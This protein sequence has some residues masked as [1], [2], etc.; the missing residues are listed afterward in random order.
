MAGIHIDRDHTLNV[1]MGATVSMI[2]FGLFFFFMGFFD[3]D[4]GLAYR[5]MLAGVESVI[6]AY[7]CDINGKPL[8]DIIFE[9][10]PVKF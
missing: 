6:I 8:L 2:A 7:N 9:K 5:L 1:G 10:K 3:A 4:I